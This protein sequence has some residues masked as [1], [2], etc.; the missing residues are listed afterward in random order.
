[1][2]LVN[3]LAAVVGYLGWF[4]T[5]AFLPL[6]L[7]FLSGSRTM[8]EAFHLQGHISHIKPT[9]F[10]PLTTCWSGDAQHRFSSLRCLVTSKLQLALVGILLHDRRLGTSINLTHNLHVTFSLPKTVYQRGRHLHKRDSP[11]D[12]GHYFERAELYSCTALEALASQ[13]RGRQLP[14]QLGRQA[15]LA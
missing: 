4:I 1:M 3:Y 14:D 5:P 7:A 15:Q 9:L 8:Q 2:L 6:E 10:F 12:E 11:A 13:Q